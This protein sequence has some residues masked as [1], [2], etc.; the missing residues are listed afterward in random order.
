M[1]LQ[2]SDKP[3]NVTTEGQGLSAVDAW[4]VEHVAKES[5]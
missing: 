2:A 4:L 3:V 1:G 5:S